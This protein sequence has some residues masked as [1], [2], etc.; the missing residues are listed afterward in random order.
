MTMKHVNTTSGSTKIIE[1][2]GREVLLLHGGTILRIYNALY[3]SKS[4]RNL[5]GLKVIR[6]NSYHVETDNEGKVEFFYITTTNVEKKIV[7]EK[8]S[9]LSSGLYYT[10]ISTVE[11]HVVVNKRFTNFNDFIIWHDRL[12]HPGFN[13]MRKIIENSHG[14]TLKSP[15][16]LQSKEFSCAACS[17][18]KLIIKH[19]QLRLELNPLRF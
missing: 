2:F 1:G 9:A 6:Q 19:Q 18:G 15:N 17:R 7:H 4:H 13:M 10:N 3:C 5:L 11:S 12:G 16:I 14:H 8:L